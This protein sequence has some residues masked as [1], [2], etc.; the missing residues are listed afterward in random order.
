MKWYT[1]VG[2]KTECPDDVFRIRTG[3]QEKDLLGVECYIWNTLL[4]SF[5]EEGQIYGRMTGLL[6]LAFPEDP[7]KA[8]VNPEEFR[9]CFERLLIRELVISQEAQTPGKAAREL[10]KTASVTCVRRTFGERFLAFCESAAFGNPI[11]SA[12]QAFKK[13]PL[14]ESHKHLLKTIQDNGEMGFP[15]KETEEGILKAVIELYQNKLLFIQSVKE[16]AL[17]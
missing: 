8:K 17:A 1:A 3:K 15:L 10:F 13:N 16:G 2:V 5:V 11:R 12:L 6:N 4:W 7:V 14:E 9:A